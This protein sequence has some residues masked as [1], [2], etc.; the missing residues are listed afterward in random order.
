MPRPLTGRIRVRRLR[1][2]TE[3]FDVRIREDQHTIGRSPRWSEKSAQTLLETKLLP[4]AMLGEQWW[5]EIPRDESI[6]RGVVT[7]GTLTVRDVLSDY[8]HLIRSRH[9]DNARTLNAYLTPIM[10]HVGPFFAVGGGRDRTM[11]DLTGSLVSDFCE[12]KRAEREILAELPAVLAELDDATLRDAEALRGQLD[13]HEWE[14]LRRFGMRGGRYR[15]SDPDGRGRF[16]I[17]S[18]GLSNNEINRCL[19]RLRDAIGVAER[20]YRIVLGDPTEGRRL[21][22][23]QLDRSWIRP[24]GLQAIF[25]AARELD[26]RPPRGGPDYR[27]LGRF[28]VC[29]LLALA[30]PRASETCNADWAHLLAEG[31]SIPEAKTHAGVRIIELHPLPRAVLEAR[32]ERQ[33]SAIGPIFATRTG[34][35]RDRNGLRNRLLSP[36]IGRA[37]ELLADRGQDPLPDRVTPHTFRRTYLTYLYWAGESVQFAKHQAGHKDARMTLEVYQQ[38]VPTKLDP[39]VAEWVRRDQ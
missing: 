2:G 12:A 33:E 17:S 18:R 28:D 19:S 34:Q 38:K 23:D 16:S 10:R 13:G 25:D 21:P 31:L 4:R 37:R 30:G 14:L 11:S 32:R 9:A 20:E 7:E 29:V 36:V 6:D 35:R 22:A 39:R 8:V 24:D 5:D 3:V 1:D 26:A 27:A 15:A